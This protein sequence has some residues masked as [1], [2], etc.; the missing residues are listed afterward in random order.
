M[1]G[2]LGLIKDEDAAPIG[3]ANHQRLF[4]PAEE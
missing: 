2:I 1:D 4:V 3:Y